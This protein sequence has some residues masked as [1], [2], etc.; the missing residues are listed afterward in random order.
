MNELE[1][2]IEAIL[3]MSGALV[4]IKKMSGIIGASVDDI[5]KSVK[6]LKNRLASSSGL[7][8]IEI[9]GS[10]QLVTD[11]ELAP[12]MQKMVKDEMVE[13]I[14]PAALE[15]LSLIAYIGPV[16]KSAIEYIRGV[17][18]SFTIRN[19]LIRG[20]IERSIHPQKANTYLYRPSADLIRHLGLS[21]VEELPDFDK[22][23]ELKK[24]LEKNEA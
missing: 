19:L 24:N 2:K 22:F 4:S 18:S 17:N 23:K 3:F 16:A 5:E 20:L 14:T 10:F 11:P 6:E 15:T 13:D 21:S 7:R 12:L 9:D 8:V 1:S